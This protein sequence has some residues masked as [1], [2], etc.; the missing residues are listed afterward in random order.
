MCQ[1][2]DRAVQTVLDYLVEQGIDRGRL[3]AKGF[4]ELQPVAANDS[5]EGR[6]RN[7]RVEV[8]ILNNGNGQMK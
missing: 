1:Q 8:K 5:E 6:Q 2:Y 7:R 4:G 3:V